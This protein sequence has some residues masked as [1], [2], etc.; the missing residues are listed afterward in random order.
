[1]PEGRADERILVIKHGALGDIILTTGAFAAIRAAHAD[2]HITLLTT[3]PFEALA[4]ASAYFDAVW[5][6]P[7]PAFRQ[8]AGWLALR[9]RLRA[10]AFARVY[11]LQTSDRSSLYFRF[12]RKPRPAWSGI[13]R[14]CSHPHTSPARDAMHT[15]DRL[16]DQ[17]AVAGIGPV[18]SPDVSWLDAPVDGY[19][20]DERFALLVPGGAAHRPRKRWPAERFAAIAA[21]LAA[22]GVQPVGL[23]TRAD[24]AALREIGDACPALLDLTDQTDFGAIAALARR[25]TVA[26][27][28]DTGPMHLIAAAGCPAIVLFS[29]DSDPALCAPRGDA[30]SVLRRDS[31]ADLAASE[32]EAALTARL[33]ASGR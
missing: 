24:G 27:G 22:R 15:L 30:V 25:A 20:L 33:S 26:I 9:R 28:N 13:A 21:W 29:N 32:V 16:A 5:S 31:L 3:P 1:M 23:G 17:L 18:P 19:S 14:G 2:A 10:G 12:F 6:D 8:V 4:R 11:D 7:R